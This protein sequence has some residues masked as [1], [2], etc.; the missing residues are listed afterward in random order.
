MLTQQTRW[1][2]AGIR[3][4]WPQI[5]M[6]SQVFGV[7]TAV[8]ADSSSHLDKSQTGMQSLFG[9][10]NVCFSNFTDL[11]RK[12]CF[13]HTKTRKTLWLQWHLT[14]EFW[15]HT[16]AITPKKSQTNPF[17]NIYWKHKNFFDRVKVPLTISNHLTSLI[18]RCLR[19]MEAFAINGYWKQN[20][21][22]RTVISYFLNYSY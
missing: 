10:F 16:P 2:A 5:W 18:R 1:P 22:H 21:K 6:R 19:Q 20:R 13:A 9:R 17:E 14:K 7:K 8:R 3:A 4:G 15:C 12:G 11:V